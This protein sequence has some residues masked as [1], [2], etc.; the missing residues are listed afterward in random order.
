MAKKG[1]YVDEQAYADANGVL[2]IYGLTNGGWW[3][4]QTGPGG[5]NEPGLPVMPM[6]PLVA[7]KK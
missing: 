5:G 2:W 7:K 4:R 1:D 6:T 3:W